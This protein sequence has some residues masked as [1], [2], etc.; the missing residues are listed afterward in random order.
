V[1]AGNPWDYIELGQVFIGKSEDVEAA[2]NGFKF[3]LIDQSNISKTEYGHRYV[4]EYP[5]KSRLEFKYDFLEYTAIQT[6][7]NAFRTNGNRTPVLVV[8][9]NAED[10]F[11]KDH[12]MIYGYMVSGFSSTHIRYDLFNADGFVVEECL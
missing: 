2:Q 1:D 3:S 10:V 5:L 9:D 6:L 7:E 11:D 4:D 12:M 8:I